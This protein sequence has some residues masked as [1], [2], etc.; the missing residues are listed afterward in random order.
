[1]ILSTLSDFPRYAA[2][3]PAFPRVIDFLA[4]ADLAALP[5]GR[6]DLDG[7]D[8]F[9][10][11]SPQARTRPASE[12][13]LEAHRRYLDIQVVL[14]GVDTLGWSPLDACRDIAV[15]FDPVKDIGFFREAPQNHVTLR[16][17]QLVVFYPEDAHA[18]LIGEGELV[19]K[20]VFKLRVA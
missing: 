14:A 2:L 15:P 3:H 18:P 5:E 6:T 20:L 16:A 13:L 11:S 1:M 7:D 17:G 12:A 9:V 4:S 8:C 19:R 10:L